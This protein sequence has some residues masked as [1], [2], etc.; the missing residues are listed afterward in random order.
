MYHKSISRV[1]PDQAALNKSCLICVC[2]VCKSV[3]KGS[4]WGTGLTENEGLHY[5]TIFFLLTIV[6]AVQNL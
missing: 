2:S 5:N 1:D 4:L 3:K 6:F